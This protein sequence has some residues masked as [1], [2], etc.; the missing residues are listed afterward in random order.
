MRKKPILCLSLAGALCAEGTTYQVGPTRP[1]PTVSSLPALDFAG[2]A[3]APAITNIP[4][5]DGQTE[6]V[7]TNAA[8][9]LQ[10]FYRVRSP[11]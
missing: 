1:Y 5:A 2:Q 8:A 6:V 10:A 4:G 3:W 11:L 7:D 9:R